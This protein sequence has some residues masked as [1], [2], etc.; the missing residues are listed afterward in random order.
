LHS[1]VGSFDELDDP[2]PSYAHELDEPLQPSQQRNARSPQVTRADRTDRVI[3][4]GTARSSGPD[5]L[6][7][8][9]LDDSGRTASVPAAPPELAEPPSAEVEAALEEADFYAAQ[10]VLETARETIEEALRASPNNAL[11]VEKLRELEALS[12]GRSVA[13]PPPPPS[14]HGDRAFDIA[15]SLDALDELDKVEQPKFTHA[16]Q[17]DVEEVFQKFKMGVAAQ[18]DASDS[19]T[20]YDLGIAYEQMMLLDDA[21]GEFKIAARD[22][23]REALCHS[24][25]GMIYRKKGQLA[26]ATEAFKAGLHAEQ[27]T[28]E[29]ELALLFELGTVWDERKNFKEAIYYFKRVVAMDGK[30]R[31]A[32]SR[33]AALE[34]KLGG[35]NEGPTPGSGARAIEDDFDAAFDE[36]I[37]GKR[38]AHQ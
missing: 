33:I 18:V 12:R 14:Q 7:R 29:E 23:T 37:A 4:T 9:E 28:R 20:H 34:K 6:P 38:K 22:P 11:L 24:M 2:L 26:D 30:Y 5:E 19:Q 25:I 21:I 8:Y 10:G 27:V 36:I 3:P 16:D 13:P 32:K 15:A 17:V 31:D 35:Q 1:Q